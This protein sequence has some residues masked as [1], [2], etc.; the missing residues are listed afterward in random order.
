MKL[1]DFSSLPIR[2]KSYGGANGNKISVII[3]NELYM[4]KLPSH[5]PKNPNLSY[6]N[7]CVSEYLVSHIFSMFGVNAQ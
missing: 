3:D 2:K 5:A 1:L 7:S 4:L 6:A